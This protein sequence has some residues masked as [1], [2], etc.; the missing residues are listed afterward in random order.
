MPYNFSIPL[1]G[2]HFIS[3]IHFVQPYTSNGGPT[4]LSATAHAP[5]C[6][7]T[8]R[9]CK[10]RTPVRLKLVQHLLYPSTATVQVRGS[11]C[12]ICRDLTK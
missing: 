8:A 12:S 4:S 3:I 5:L 7:V 9:A 11:D 6:D 10:W 2:P 1:L